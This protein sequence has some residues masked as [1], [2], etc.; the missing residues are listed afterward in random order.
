M[1]HL[2]TAES[3]E[4]KAKRKQ[5]QAR[6]DAMFEKIVN[7]DVKRMLKSPDIEL[8]KPVYKVAVPKGRKK[9]L[10]SSTKIPDTISPHFGTSLGYLVPFYADL[11]PLSRNIIGADWEDQKVRRT[12]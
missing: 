6:E 12:V 7:K 3:A 10:N 5:A 9:Q 4:D 2:P 1:L 8:G 11:S